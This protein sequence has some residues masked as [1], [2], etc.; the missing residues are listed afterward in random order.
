M[1]LFGPSLQALMTRRVQPYEQ[2]QLQ[3][4]NASLMGITGMFGPLLFTQVFSR[5]IS[6]RAPVHLPGAPFL[7]AGLL[8]LAGAV[9]AT[10]ITQTAS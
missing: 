7:L 9:L 3:G 4:A 1:G 6:P 5:A 2:G 8:L 10:R